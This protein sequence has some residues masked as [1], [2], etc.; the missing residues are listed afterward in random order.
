MKTSKRAVKIVTICMIASFLGTGCAHQTRISSQPSRA[1]VSIDGEYIG[2]TPI[3]YEDNSGMGKEYSIEIKKR[4]YEP[5]FSSLRQDQ[6]NTGVLVGSV[7]GA[8]ICCLP[9][10]GLIWARQLKNNYSYELEKITADHK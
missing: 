2:R 9:G 7:V 8:A 10:I 5:V 4:G 6:W 3:M 1:K